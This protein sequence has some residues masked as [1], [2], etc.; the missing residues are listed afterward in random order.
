MAKQSGQ[1]AGGKWT[2]PAPTSVKP[3]T[4]KPKAG[5]SSGVAGANK[6]ANTVPHDFSVAST[7]S[8]KN[9]HHGV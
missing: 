5:I 7:L 6:H 2:I 9:K 4:A 1:T 8:A 3:E